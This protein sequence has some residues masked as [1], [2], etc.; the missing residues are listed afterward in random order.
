MPRLWLE[1]PAIASLCVTKVGGL[2]HDCPP[3]PEIWGTRPAVPLVDTPVR[4]DRG[5]R[6]GMALKTDVLVALS[7]ILAYF[8]LNVYYSHADLWCT[9]LN[10]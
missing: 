3:R 4:V 1:K 2:L 9:M 10:E 5:R 6:I 8:Y 7:M